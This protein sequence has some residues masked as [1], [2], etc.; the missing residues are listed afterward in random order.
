MAEA[1]KKKPA[2]KKKKPV[3]KKPLKKK[4]VVSKKA[5][6]KQKIGS[7]DDVMS[8]GLRR[9]QK[10][11]FVRCE[12]NEP[13]YFLSSGNTVLD[14]LLT[15]GKGYAGGVVYEY[16][17]DEHTGKT[18]DWI[19]FGKQVQAKG[20]NVVLFDA[21]AG[22][23]SELAHLHGLITT[24]P[25]FT[26]IRPRTLEAFCD[27]WEEFCEAAAKLDVPTLLVIDS[28]AGLCPEVMSKKKRTMTGK[29][30]KVG[31][32][33]RLFSWF[34]RRGFVH[35]I[36]GSKVFVIFVNQVRSVIG[37]GGMFSGPQYTTSAGKTLK[38]YA[39][40]RL[41][42]TEGK[43]TTNEDGRSV[44]ATKTIYTAKNKI[45]GK[46]RSAKMP[47][48]YDEAWDDNKGILYYLKSHKIFKYCGGSTG[49][50][51]LPGVDYRGPLVRGESSW[52]GQ[53]RNSHKFRAGMRRIVRLHF[54]S[55]WTADDGWIKGDT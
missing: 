38:F 16:F 55:Q 36:A 41:Q 9:V 29:D 24:E 34:F 8:N 31:E 2:A 37:G 13:Q 4:K 32:E 42:F 17:G 46:G 7:W 33:A 3:K 35:D 20:G 47:I 21:E 12:D 54:K 30:R 11:D 26:R 51:E 22:F 23:R 27:M 14:L 25:R 40:T 45:I 53:M 39:N 49:N 19:I 28:V 1:K 18:T 15:N 48:F 52:L 43:E 44:G 6:K 10:N 5:G 50:W